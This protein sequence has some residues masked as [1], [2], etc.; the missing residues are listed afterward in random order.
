MKEALQGRLQP[1]LQS[2][3]EYK[4]MRSPAGKLT[5]KRVLF[6]LIFLT[7]LL[8]AVYPYIAYRWNARRDEK[9]IAGYTKTYTEG[10]ETD[11]EEDCAERIREAQAYNQSLYVPSVPDAFSIRD[12]VRDPVYEA[13]LNPQGSGMMGYVE[14][15]AI[16][17]ELPIYHYTTDSVL[18]QGAGHLLG[19]ALPVGGEGTHCVISA[20]R[21]LANA[22]M[23]TDLNLLRE[24]D[25]FYFHILDQVFAYEVDQILV[26]EPTEVDALKAFEGEDLATLVTCTP[27]AVN[28]HRLLV[29]GHRIPY[30][31]E[32]IALERQE[33]P[34]S[35]TN[36]LAAQALCVAAGI[37][38]AWLIVALIQLFG[39]KKKAE[40]QE[41][42]P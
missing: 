8:I 27:Y 12:G 26:V 18:N 32:T 2:H 29:R 38:I 23:F 19:S 9:L 5:K 28:T 20:H 17:V 6:A 21:G 11:W 35:D 16:E 41:K 34:R 25:R 33:A 39:R 36:Y 22:R 14:I 37:G 10:G 7:G 3:A 30:S 13:Y 24:G 42:T 40:R 4:E 15:P 1:V 31:E